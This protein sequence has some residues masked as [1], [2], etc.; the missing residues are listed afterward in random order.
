MT[1]QRRNLSAT[2]VTVVLHLIAVPILAQD[3]PDCASLCRNNWLESERFAWMRLCH[4]KIADFNARP[5]EAIIALEN[6]SCWNNGLNPSDKSCWTSSR[7]IRSLFLDDILF[8]DALQNALSGNPV[9]IIG[10]YFVEPIDLSYRTIASN[11]F[12]DGSRFSGSVSMAWIHAKRNMSFDSSVVEGSVNLEGA[13][14]DGS[15]WMR[16]ERKESYPATFGAVN[17]RNAK[18]SGQLS[19]AHAHLESVDMDSVHIGA[20]LFLR[21]TTVSGNLNLIFASIESNI[22]LGG[23]T[24]HV[25][26]LSGATIGGELRMTEANSVR[27]KNGGSISMLNTHVGALVEISAS[28]PE[29][30]RSE[31]FVFSQLGGFG[32]TAEDAVFR[33][34]AADYSWLDGGENGSLQPYEHLASILRK[35]GNNGVANDVLFDGKQSQQRQAWAD[36]RL[37]AWAWL[38]LFQIVIGYGYRFVNAFYLSLAFLLVGCSVALSQ[39]QERD[40]CRTIGPTG[41]WFSVD[42]LLPVV[43]L[44]GAHFEDVKLNR[45]ARCYFYF[46]RLMGYVL[47]LFVVAGLSGLVK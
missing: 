33:R 2:I 46:H 5:N 17:L 9:H 45:I 38:A 34:N 24:L 13:R 26:D 41:F 30:V 16:K 42:Y 44:N 10:A 18:V 31:G 12:L 28:W 22:V 7:N 32:D 15:L 43:E 3:S 29:Q 14:V 4:G 27:W 6:P 36:G 47:V 25:L 40:N 1:V 11:L 19:M 39:R 23:A 37:G 35:A 20:D 21:E 8:D